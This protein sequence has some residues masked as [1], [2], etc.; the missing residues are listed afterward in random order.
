MH[1]SASAE[2]PISPSVTR[3]MTFPAARLDFLYVADDFVV[4]HV[5]GGNHHHGHFGVDEGDGAV[6]HLGGGVA[7]GMDVGYLLELERSLEGTG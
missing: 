1:S 6:L 2:M 3:A 7:L 5:A 4:Q